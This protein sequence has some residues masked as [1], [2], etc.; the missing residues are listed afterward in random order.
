M[1][2]TC[3]YKVIHVQIKPG[4]IYGQYISVILS[5]LFAVFS[6]SPIRNV[7]GE[8]LPGDVQ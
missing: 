2:Y 4:E 1:Y 7:L 6:D 3:A 5:N 8:G